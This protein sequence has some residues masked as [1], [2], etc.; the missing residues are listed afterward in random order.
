MNIIKK[1]ALFCARTKYCRQA[2]E[3]RADLSAMREKPT[4]KMMIGLGLVAFS[5]VIGLPAVI[6][7][8][9]IAVWLR[10]PLVGIVGGPLIYAISTIIFIVGIKMAGKK[11]FHVFSRWLV[12]VALE[13]ILGEDI[14]AVCAPGPDDRCS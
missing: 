5:Y 8:G 6:A 2:I 7:M 1:A 10:E 4:A 12:R 9:I 3:E 13:K 11:Y 14:R